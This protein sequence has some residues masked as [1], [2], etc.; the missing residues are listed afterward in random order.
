MD[1]NKLLTHMTG[2]TGRGTTMEESAILF[3]FE[4]VP[5][6]HRLS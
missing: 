5:A 3:G 2:T 6:L 1:F 4:S